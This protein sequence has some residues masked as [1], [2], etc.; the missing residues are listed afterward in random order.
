M[1]RAL[2]AGANLFFWEPGYEAL[3]RL[4]AARRQQLLVVTGSYEGDRRSI[5]A[6]VEQALRR[7]RTDHLDVF[8]L[9]WVRSPERLSDEV[10]ET[11]HE[12]KR[13]GKIRTC[14]FSTHDRELASLAIR[15]GGWDVLM[16]RHSAAHPGAEQSLFPLCATQGTGV[17]T[18]SATS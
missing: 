6:D 3:T 18:F 9:F 15:S 17:L 8:L 1:E 5:V 13:A 12:L 11:L 16:T 7:L 4:I 2:A 10:R 14:G